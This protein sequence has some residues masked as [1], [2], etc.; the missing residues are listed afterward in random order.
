[1][2]RYDYECIKCDV[3]FDIFVPLE[4]FDEKIKCPDC[5]TVLK[6]MISPVYFRMG[7]GK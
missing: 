6:R 5:N 1:M 2:P 4:K 3:V 7:N